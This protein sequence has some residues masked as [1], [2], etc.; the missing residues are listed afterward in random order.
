MK[1]RSMPAPVFYQLISCRAV[2]LYIR[3]IVSVIWRGPVEGGA[4]TRLW[5]FTLSLSNRVARMPLCIIHRPHVRFLFTWLMCQALPYLRTPSCTEIN[6]KCSCE[7]HCITLC[8][9]W[10]HTVPIRPSTY[11]SLG[12]ISFQPS[13]VQFF[14]LSK[15]ENSICRLFVKWEPFRSNASAGSIQYIQIVEWEENG[16]SAINEQF[17]TSETKCMT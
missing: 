4:A 7:R 13:R 12:I 8:V 10:K 15:L 1:A 5:E 3:T 2:P 16:S 9:Q 14:I 17:T 11:I 6:K